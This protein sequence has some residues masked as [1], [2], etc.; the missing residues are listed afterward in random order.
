M[1]RLKSATMV[2]G[3]S[4]LGAL[5]MLAA[6]G[7][8]HA[9]ACGQTAS[10]AQFDSFYAPLWGCQQTRINDMWSRF[11]F[12]AGDWDQG[13][14]YEAACND[15][16]PL[17]RTFNALQLLAYGVT[18][19]PTCTVGGANVATW[20]YCYSGNSIDELDGSCETDVRAHTRWGPFIDN[21]TRLKVP[22]FY[23][24]T[25]VQRAGTVFHEARHAQGWCAHDSNCI[26][27]NSS[28]DPSFYGGCVGVG[29]SSGNGANGYT[30]L[31]AAWFASTARST[32]TN[33]TI[34]MDAVNEGNRYLS[35]RF[36]TDPC[37][38]LDS[39]GNAFTTC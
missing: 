4:A 20:A 34:R 6:S 16:L 10:T 27:G 14:G 12:D 13:M 23:D 25:V 22:F 3:F 28:C 8:A 36:G 2:K 32:W 39:N 17:K 5:A 29:S 18:A 30:V 31:F 26:D 19:T 9:Q 24:E 38:R 1:K 11:S 7:T 15:S 33:P 21:W 37:F 35:N